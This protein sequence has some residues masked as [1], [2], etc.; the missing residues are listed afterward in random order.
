MEKK[1]ARIISSL[2]LNAVIALVL[3][4]FAQQL[5][6]WKGEIPAFSMQQFWVNL[7]IAY[8]GACLV[9]LI[10]SVK[11]GTAFAGKCGA[12]PDTLKFALLMNLVV[13]TV[14]TFFMCILMTYVNVGLLGGAPMIAVVF[15]ILG[16]FVPIWCVCFVVSFV[17][18]PLCQKLAVKL[19]SK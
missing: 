12:T 7:P 15:G 10:P 11:W 9:C 2:L 8:V 1:S 3:C 6:V 13:N 16:G 19:T 18:A 17:F 5:S 4:W 14:F